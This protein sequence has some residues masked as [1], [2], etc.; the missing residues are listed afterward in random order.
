MSLTLSF[1]NSQ[2]LYGEL[3]LSQG[4]RAF[5]LIRL[6]PAPWWV[7]DLSCS[8]Q[9]Y[10]LDSA[11]PYK[12]LSYAWENG[13]NH[14]D[15]SLR[16]NGIEISIGWNLYGALRRLRQASRPVHVWVDAICINQKDDHERTYQV[17]MMRTIYEKSDEVAIWLGAGRERD[18]MGGDVLPGF[19]PDSPPYVDWQGGNGKQD[20]ALWEAFVARQKSRQDTMDIRNRDIFGAFCVL[21]LLNVGVEA[22]QIIH[23]RHIGQSV[24]ILNGLDAIMEQSW[25]SRTWV[26]QETIVATQ[27]VVYYGNLSAPWGMFA[28]AA[29]AYSG[30][31]LANSIESAYPY[32]RSLSR[33]SSTVGEIESVRSAWLDKARLVT[34]L[35]LLRRFR[36]RHATDPRDKVYALLGVV[37]SWEG[38]ERLIPDYGLDVQ[39]VFQRTTVT[40]IKLTQSLEA[41]I[42]TT[43]NADISWVTDW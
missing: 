28:G 29:A 43:G 2:I 39:Q 25:W 42:G 30:K 31:K 24:T 1:R 22:A 35:T 16:C 17:Q 10:A 15:A 21:W 37:Q 13:P 8:L 27:A 5:R 9:E 4:A 18:M 26:L 14:R 12:A 3:N 19:S 20:K 36:T 33:F 32:I 34:L 41:L 6:D 23:L 38:Q 11:P 40:V 7:Q